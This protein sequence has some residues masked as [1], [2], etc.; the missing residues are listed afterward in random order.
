MRTPSERHNIVLSADPVTLFGTR[1]DRRFSTR[2]HGF[3]K[4]LVVLVGKAAVGADRDQVGNDVGM[5]PRQTVLVRAVLVVAV[6]IAHAAVGGRRILQSPLVVVFGIHQILGL[7]RMTLS[8]G[9]IL[10][11]RSRTILGRR[12]LHVF[13]LDIVTGSAVDVL[14][15]TAQGER[16]DRRVVASKANHRNDGVL[17]LNHL[18]TCSPVGAKGVGIHRGNGDDRRHC[19]SRCSHDC[20]PFLGSKPH[21]GKA[22]HLRLAFFP[23][24]SA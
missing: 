16:L 13:G 14:V 20:S 3:G 2:T 6:D 8:A 15:S 23:F 19:Q 1:I 10:E 17:G 21:Q 12:R 11:V 9:R 22:Y 7:R 4:I 24:V 5:E 18:C